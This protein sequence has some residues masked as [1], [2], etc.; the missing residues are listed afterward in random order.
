[1]NVLK[2][3][4]LILFSIFNCFLFMCFRLCCLQH[5]FTIC[6]LLTLNLNP[7]KLKLTGFIIHFIMYTLLHLV[8]GDSALPVLAFINH[9]FANLLPACA[10]EIN[11]LLPVVVATL[12]PI[13][14]QQIHLGISNKVVFLFI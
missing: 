10:S 7:R 1:M 3:F 2:Q 5:Y 11:A 6:D 4:V 12:I 8:S 14:Q 13:A 9:M